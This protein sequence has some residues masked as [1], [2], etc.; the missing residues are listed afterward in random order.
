MWALEDAGKH[1][2]ADRVK[3]YVEPLTG[4]HCMCDRM[5]H[6]IYDDGMID[7][8]LQLIQEGCTCMCELKCLDYKLECFS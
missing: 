5:H 2:A 8:L 7:H 6:F 1:Q 4:E 3:P